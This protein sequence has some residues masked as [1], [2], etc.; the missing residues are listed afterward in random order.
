MEVKAFLPGR[1]NK[2]FIYE[3]NIAEFAKDR[4]KLLSTTE[5]G[6]KGTGVSGKRKWEKSEDEIF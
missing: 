4:D 6:Q 1:N 3:K 5:I 2:K